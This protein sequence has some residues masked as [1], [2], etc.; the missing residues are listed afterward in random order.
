MPVSFFYELILMNL[1][2]VRFPLPRREGIQGRGIKMAESQFYSPSPWPSPV[3]G[4]E[5]IGLI[6]TASIAQYL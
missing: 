4:E 2:I 1:I 6:E 3:K 5:T